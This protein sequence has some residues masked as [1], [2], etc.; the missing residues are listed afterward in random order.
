MHRAQ[1][2]DLPA[3]QG[4]VG[5]QAR[6]PDPVA[7]QVDARQPGG[8]DRRPATES[9]ARRNRCRASDHHAGKESAGHHVFL[10]NAG[11]RQVGLQ[12]GPVRFGFGRTI[13]DGSDDRLA[14]WRLAGRR[15][16][17]RRVHR[18][19]NTKDITRVGH[20]PQAS[21][22]TGGGHFGTEVAPSRVSGQ[23]PDGCRR[24]AGGDDHRACG[25]RTVARGH[26]DPASGG[27]DAGDLDP[28]A[29]LAE[30]GQSGVIS[31]AQPPSRYRTPLAARC[32]W[33][34]AASAANVF[35]SEAYVVRRTSAV[36]AATAAGP[37]PAPAIH[38]DTEAP[39]CRCG[40]SRGSRARSAAYASLSF[41]PRSVVRRSESGLVG[42]R[43]SSPP[44]RAW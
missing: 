34:I 24:A 17:D 37:K 43:W 11:S 7:G 32:N 19:I 42:R 26:L 40:R 39:A 5:D 30:G 2:G 29:H 41:R 1:S 9:A 10:P 6:R 36:T 33:A 16:L 25:Q 12:D 4:R 22:E 13:T 23:Q 15:R 38:C 18:G 8:V 31:W 44:A 14:R 3:G 21:V 20:P 28:G 35:M 27:P